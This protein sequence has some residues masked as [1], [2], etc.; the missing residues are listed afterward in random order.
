[1]R[2]DGPGRQSIVRQLFHGSFGIVDLPAHMMKPLAVLRE[3]GRQRMILRERFNEL[4][5]AAR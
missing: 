1:M 5:E 3:M 4:K 2:L